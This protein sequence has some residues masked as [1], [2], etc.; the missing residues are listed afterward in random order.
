MVLIT[1][2]FKLVDETE[3]RALESLPFD[4]D[5]R[6]CVKCVNASLDYKF[7]GNYLKL[8]QFFS[9]N[10]QRVPLLQAGFTPVIYPPSFVGN[11]LYITLVNN[12]RAVMPCYNQKPSSVRGNPYTSPYPDVWVSR[13]DAAEVLKISPEKVR[14]QHIF[15]KLFGVDIDDD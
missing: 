4:W 9:I 14:L 1:D 10:K 15:S 12:L 6:L 3:Q 13:L 2:N 8:V 11:E 7:Y 5:K